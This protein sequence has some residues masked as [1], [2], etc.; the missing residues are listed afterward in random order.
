MNRHRLGIL[1]LAPIQ[2]DGKVLRQIEYA[3]RE[4]EV[5]VVGWGQMDNPRPHVGMR[6][7]PR[8]VFPPGQRLFQALLMFGGRFSPN[9]WERWYW[10]KPDHRQALDLLV[11]NSPELIHANEALSLPIGIE[12]ARRTGARVLFDAHEYT[13]DHRANNLLWRVLAQPLYTYLIRAYA[14]RAD[15]MITV[16][17]GIAEKYRERFGLTADVITNAPPYVALPFRATDPERIRLIHH[18]GAIRERNM[19]EMV[20]A[21]ALTDARF[22]LDFMLIDGTPGYLSKFRTWAERRVPGR[23][24][25]RDPVAPAQIAET[26]N[27]YDIGLFLIP[28]VNLSYAMA[29]PNKFFEFIMA[30]LAVAIG[31]SPAM[32]DIVRQHGLGI[33][34]D[35]FAPADLAA[36]LNH[37]G[38]EQIDVMKRHSL[39]AARVLNAD[40]EMDKLLG[41]YRRLLP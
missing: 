29:L 35:T 40:I 36:C 10:R 13:P 39:A 8:H 19:E 30:G 22:S 34:A 25:F 7:V 21:L 11:E 28:P 38:H 9:L 16:G 24:R 23:I 4:Y 5:T 12:T 31:P 14:P 15:A 6:S 17:S 3:A 2:T 37:L 27:E 41:I 18:G 20:E 33:V 26:I 1:R 32:A